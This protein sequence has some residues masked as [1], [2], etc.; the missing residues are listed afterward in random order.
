MSLS[1]DNTSAFDV[2]ELR[3][4]LLDYVF[5]NSITPNVIQLRLFTSF[6]T[7]LRLTYSDYVY[8]RLTWR[9]Y[10]FRNFTTSFVPKLRPVTS[11]AA[12][13]CCCSS[14]LDLVQLDSWLGGGGSTKDVMQ[15]RLTELDYVF[16][17][18]SYNVCLRLSCL[19]Y[20]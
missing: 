2:T 11:F 12:V 14:C 17:R 8:L 15:L 5:R 20:V 10:V 4:T 9:L 7:Q 19:I 16:S 18:G 3:L 6:V 1:P 13:P